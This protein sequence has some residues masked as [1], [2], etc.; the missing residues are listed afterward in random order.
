MPQGT[1][2]PWKGVHSG[3]HAG[4]LWQLAEVVLEVPTVRSSLIYVSHG[5]P[6]RFRVVIANLGFRWRGECC[7]GLLHIV[8]IMELGAPQ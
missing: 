2:L 5:G 1:A 8:C 6:G 3:D 7:E 4:E